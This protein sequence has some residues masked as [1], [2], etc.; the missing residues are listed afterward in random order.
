MAEQ[1]IDLIE[2][3]HAVAEHLG[4]GWSAEPLHEPWCSAV[5]HGPEDIHV[6]M[7][8]L[9][10]R[11]VRL[12]W[13]LPSSPALAAARLLPA[14]EIVVSINRGPAAIVAGIQRRILPHARRALF[15]LRYEQARRDKMLAEL[16]AAIGIP[17]L[18][19]TH[20]HI[21]FGEGNANTPTIGISVAEKDQVVN[22]TLDLPARHALRVAQAIGRA[23]SHTGDPNN[24]TSTE[25]GA[26]PGAG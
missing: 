6:L 8:E 12:M 16:A 25:P 22:L 17:V 20:G 5:L 1:P 24:E 3:A 21:R 11:Q 18:N 14:R 2:L 9:G 7:T 23:L 19:D 4:A 15:V 26:E 13:F 10:N